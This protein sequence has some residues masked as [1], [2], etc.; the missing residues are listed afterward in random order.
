MSVN[1]GQ[2]L[3]SLDLLRGV[4]IF[5]LT[6][7]W[8]P[9]Y[10]CFSK[11]APTS[12][13]FLFI[14][15]QLA[16]FVTP[17][18]P[19]YGYNI[20]DLAQPLFV[21]ICG[22]AVPFAI[23]KRLSP[24]GKATR[25]FWRHVLQRVAMLWVLGCLIRNVLSFDLSR[26][27]PY[28]DT[29]HT[30]AVAY[31]G[32]ALAQ[33]IRQRRVRFALALALI[34]V[35][36]LL[37]HTLGDYTRLGNISRIIDETVFGAIGCKAKDYC[38]ILTTI[39]W[40]AM[41]ILGSLGTNLLMEDRNVWSRAMRLALCG[42]V[43]LAF[44]Y[45]LGIWIPFIRYIYTTSFI[46]A[47]IGWAALLYSAF[48]VVTDI[49]HFRRGTGIFLLFGQCSLAAW[50]LANFFV[51]GIDAVVRRCTEGAAVLFGGHEYDDVLLGFGRCLFVMIL[52]ALWRRLKTAKLSSA[53]LKRQ[54]R[55]QA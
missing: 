29:L 20:K 47:S 16:S 2:R 5:F 43:S 35:Y 27:T 36:G 13:A 7:L 21:F 14:D 52:V 41:G 50:M 34:A 19:L 42:G 3:F 51:G 37:Q 25:A 46:F 8:A 53:N 44:G 30:I 32:A 31:F 54:E 11:W 55:K 24:E 1:A 45:F 4:D 10:F 23:P 17:D 15:H 12:S 6:A 9:L 49:W 38:Y 26:F 22:A 39:P 48:F 18:T 28:S 40:A 33:L